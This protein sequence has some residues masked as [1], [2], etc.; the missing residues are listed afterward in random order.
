MRPLFVKENNH[1]PPVDGRLCEVTDFIYLVGAVSPAPRKMHEM[2]HGPNKYLLNERMNKLT[3]QEG[4][5]KLS[6]AV[7]V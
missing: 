1:V 4:L 6:R 2:Y 5:C 3:D 7:Q